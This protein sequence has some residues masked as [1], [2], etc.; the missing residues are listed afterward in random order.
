MNVRRLFIPAASA[1][2]A[3][4]VAVPAAATSTVQFPANVDY[5]NT[6]GYGAYSS[7]VSHDSY[8]QGV[9]INLDW[10]SVETSPGNYT[11]GPLD[12]TATA[13]ANAHKHI[14]L[15]VRAANETGGATLD[16]NLV[17]STCKPDSDQI[18]PA[19]VISALGYNG[20][21]CDSDLETIV[22]DWFSPAFQSYFQEFVSA[23][24]KHVSKK[25]YFSSISYVRIGVGLGGEAFPVMPDQVGS[26]CKTSTLPCQEDSSADKAWMSQY[27]GYSGQAWQKFQETMLTAYDAAFPSVP[28]IYPID[29]QD[30]DS[31]GKPVDLVVA[32]WA[33]A[34]YSNIGIGAECL[35][36]GGGSLETYADFGTIDTWIRD[37]HPGAYIQF[38]T[39]GKTA[40]AAEEQGIIK[41]AEGFGARSVEWYEDTFNPTKGTP[42][43]ASDMTGYQTWVN[44]NCDPACP[45]R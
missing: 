30:N 28:L 12:R 43:S 27:W 19:W 7:T 40:T 42:P 31:A 45:P 18:L 10:R 4:A 3:L 20:T 14:V 8:V 33:I 35:P 25:K 6:G 44:S 1:A 9:D 29:K 34:T 23:L 41:A 13:W 21:Y 5:D 26:G 38:Q 24:G 17:P 39:C 15:V 2:V 37:N 16:K 36:P 22:P 32:K 11:W